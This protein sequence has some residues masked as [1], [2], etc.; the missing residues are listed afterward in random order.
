MV[1]VDDFLQYLDN[2]IVE[3][4]NVFS[5]GIVESAEVRFVEEKRCNIDT[6]VRALSIMFCHSI[7]NSCLRQDFR[8]FS[9][10]QYF[11]YR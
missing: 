3:K 6:M 9:A 10:T 8:R 11:H 4:K 1:I 7:L 5:S 2:V